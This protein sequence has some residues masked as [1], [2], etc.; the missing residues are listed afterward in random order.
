MRS[1]I[2]SILNLI[3][4]PLGLYGISLFGSR[5]EARQE[6]EKGIATYQVPDKM[7][8]M[9]FVFPKIKVRKFTLRNIICTAC[10]QVLMAITLILYG[11]RLV[12]ADVEFSKIVRWLM[13]AMLLICFTNV[14]ISKVHCSIIDQKLR[15]KKRK[16]K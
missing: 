14:M 9:L 12:G 11:L 10:I 2:V 5:S 7:K 1:L 6:D 3:F 15:M 8:M 4:G 16:E 13:I